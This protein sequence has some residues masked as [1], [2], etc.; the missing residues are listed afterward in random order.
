MGFRLSGDFAMRESIAAAKRKVP[1][2]SSARGR[3]GR[4]QMEKPE[5]AREIAQKPT[6]YVQEA[7][8]KAKATTEEGKEARERTMAAVSKGAADL[9]LQLLEMVRTNTNSAFEFAHRLIVVKSPSEFFELSVTHA[10][11]QLES[12]TEQTQQFAALAQKVAAETVAPLQS[13]MMRNFSR[14][15]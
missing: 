14:V 15:A 4:E 13:G 6:A 1:H 11:K 8:E 10:R 5:A 7:L 3:S 9:N 12:L 2:D